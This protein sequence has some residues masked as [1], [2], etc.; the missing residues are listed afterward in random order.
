MLL[1]VGAK[2]GVVMRVIDQE[3]IMAGVAVDLGTGQAAM[4]RFFIS[5]KTISRERFGEKR[6]S[7]VK[8]MTKKLANLSP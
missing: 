8:P 2:H 4:P 3:R 7:L 5:A 6:Q 1:H